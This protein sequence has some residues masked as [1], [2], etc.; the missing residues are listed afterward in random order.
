MKKPY[1]TSRADRKLSKASNDVLGRLI[2][3]MGIRTQRKIE[4]YSER[5]FTRKDGKKWQTA[6]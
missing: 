3:D 6:S 1:R 5:N 2:P 4:P